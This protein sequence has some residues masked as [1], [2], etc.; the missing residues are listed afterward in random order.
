MTIHYS[1]GEVEAV[2]DFAGVMK[3][4]RQLFPDAVAYQGGFEV[5]DDDEITSDEPIYVWQDE[6]SSVNDSGAKAVAKIENL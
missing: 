6:S 3:S 4:V 5:T 1:N 2:A